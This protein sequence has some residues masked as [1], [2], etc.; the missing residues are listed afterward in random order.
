MYMIYMKH[1]IFKIWLFAIF[2]NVEYVSFQ[3]RHYN[4]LKSYVGLN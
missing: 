1:I 3:V 2:G 4:Y